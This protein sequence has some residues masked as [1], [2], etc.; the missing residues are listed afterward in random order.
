MFFTVCTDIYN[1]T[2]VTVTDISRSLAENLKLTGPALISYPDALQQTVKI[3]TSIITKK[4]PCQEDL[5]MEE[6]ADLS[7]IE[8]TEFDWLVIDSAMDVISG[9]AVA[10]GPSFAE[11]WKIFEK[12]VLRYASSGESLERASACGVLA[13]TITGM[14]EG[15]TP[16]TPSMMQVLLKRLGDE[17]AQTKSNAAYAVGRLVEKSNDDATVVKAYPQILSK[18]EALFGITEGRC[19]DNA[20][21]CVSRLILKHRNKVPVAEVLPALVSSGVLPLKEDYEENEPVWRM[22]VQMCKLYG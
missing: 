5:A 10:L 9:M 12:Q 17:D 1:S 18:L 2:S 4:H 11:L 15:V 19:R 3:I 7:D 20:A 16:F 6:E 21:G 8:T 14:D 13:E 22:I